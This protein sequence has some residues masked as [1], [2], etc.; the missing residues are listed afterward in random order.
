[1]SGSKV[2]TIVLGSNQ[3]HRTWKAQKNGTSRVKPRCENKTLLNF[4]SPKDI[5][6][7]GEKIFI[8]S[9]LNQARLS[10]LTSLVFFHW[11]KKTNT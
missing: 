8:K 11:M 3:P 7:I 1:M 6:Y 4:V 10:P 9:A 5:D 2:I